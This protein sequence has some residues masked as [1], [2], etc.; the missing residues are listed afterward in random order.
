MVHFLFH[1]RKSHRL[2]IILYVSTSFP[3]LLLEAVSRI[4][5]FRP[6]IVCIVHTYISTF[7]CQH[8]PP[9][10]PKTDGMSLSLLVI[11]AFFL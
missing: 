9:R 2:I 10:L 8:N 7:S 1:G 11:D 6:Q 3:P 5:E 4:S